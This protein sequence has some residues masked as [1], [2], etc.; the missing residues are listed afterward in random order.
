LLKPDESVTAPEQPAPPAENTEKKAAS[1]TKPKAKQ[2][3]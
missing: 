1:S 3:K 2:K